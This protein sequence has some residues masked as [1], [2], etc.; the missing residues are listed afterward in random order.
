M[1]STVHMT[2]TAKQSKTSLVKQIIILNKYIV[3][4][5]IF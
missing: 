1:Q 4:I 5:L 2:P 3:K